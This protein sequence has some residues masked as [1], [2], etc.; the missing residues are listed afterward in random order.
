MI[1]NPTL[2][3]RQAGKRFIFSHKRVQNW[4]MKLIENEMI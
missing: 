4:D 1:L 3:S 2:A